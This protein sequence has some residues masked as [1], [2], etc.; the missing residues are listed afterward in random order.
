MFRLL[1][2]IWQEISQGEN[3]DVYLTIVAAITI[4]GLELVGISTPWTA[5]LTLAVLGLLAVSSLINRR[6]T[7]KIL[8][9]LSTS[10]A[11][12]LLDK[13]A[14]SRD[15]D[16]RNAKDLWLIGSVLNK[17][18]H[19][20][21]AVFHEK[22]KRGDRLR[23]IL[24]SPEGYAIKLVAA[25]KY[26]PTEPQEV[27]SYSS[28]TLNSLCTLQKE[29]PKQLEIRVVDYPLQFGIIAA[30]IKSTSAS[31]HVEYHSFR[32]EMDAPILFLQP[33]DQKWF[34]FFQRQVE[35]LWQNGREWKCASE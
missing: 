28:L 4:A 1:K 27:Q 31:I 9:R 33:R 32:M 26:K 10:A 19:A 12:V 30:D 20:Y 3:I 35:T 18:V 14:P 16:I 24:V 21:Y 22:L 34:D 2:G 8:Q 23:F 25:R 13:F 7:E 29:F 11:D 17:T 15:T 6:Q 5:P